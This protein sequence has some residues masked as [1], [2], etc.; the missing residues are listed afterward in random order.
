MTNRPEAALSFFPWGPVPHGTGEGFSPEKWPFARLRTG[1][2]VL[3]IE[4][5]NFENVEMLGG[6]VTEPPAPRPRKN[7]VFFEGRRQRKL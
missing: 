1:S 5:F 2:L 4:H 6:E 7:D 3:R